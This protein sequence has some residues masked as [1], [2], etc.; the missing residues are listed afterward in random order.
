MKT[1][2]CQEPFHNK[3]LPCCAPGAA[4][5]GT[6]EFGALSRCQGERNPWRGEHAHCTAPNYSA[7]EL[8]QCLISVAI[9]K[10]HF[11]DNL[12]IGF[13]V[14]FAPLVARTKM[15]NIFSIYLY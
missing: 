14:H 5:E 11:S 10:Y 9:I 2:T 8:L 1:V 13:F 3:S 12:K 4:V 15:G 7:Q 6:D